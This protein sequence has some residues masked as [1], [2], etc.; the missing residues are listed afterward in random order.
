MVTR[1]T[2][3]AGYAA[4]AGFVLAAIFVL[5]SG[6]AMSTVPPE[7]G[8]GTADA[9]ARFAPDRIL[10]KSE[11]AAAISA[12]NRRSGASAE[13]AAGSGVSVV[14]L[15]E[16]LSVEDAVKRYEDL[17]GVEYAEPDFVMREDQS[18]I[19][20]PNDPRFGRQ[21]GLRNTGAEGGV[22]D[23]DIDASAAWTRTRGTGEAV[24]AVVDSGNDVRHPD[25]YPN[26]WVNDDERPSNRKDDDRNGYVD[27][28]RGW[29]FFNGDGTLYHGFEED[30]HGTHVAGIIAARGNNGLGMTGIGWRVKVMPLKFIGPGGSGYISDAARAVDYAAKNGAHVVNISSGCDDCYSQTLR[31]AIMRAERAGV[32]VVTT[33]GNSG[34]NNNTRRHYPCRYDLPNVLCVA[35]TDRRD[36]LAGFSNYGSNTVD[37]AAPGVEVTGTVPGGGYRRYTGTSQAS[38]HVA[39]VAALVESEFPRLDAAGIK[40]RILRS[41]DRKSGLSGKTVTGGRLNA[42]K[43]LK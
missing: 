26:I 9:P 12:E 32:L 1:R 10:V 3:R 16:D 17:P 33:A 25:L 14:G 5:T 42:S 21:W 19:E 24:V 30:D 4:C 6:H 39:G 27:D 34:A 31:D 40:A 11:D 13:R 18:G 2:G 36:A 43:A 23:A 38:P 28:V 15:P 29:D 22:S 41:V 35:A 37:L 8:S 7:G 20:L